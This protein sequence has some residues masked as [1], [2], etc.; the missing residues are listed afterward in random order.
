MTSVSSTPGR[1]SRL[2]L[3]ASRR[4]QALALT[5][6]LVALCA[7]IAVAAA[8]L[9]EA[10]LSMDETRLSPSAA[11]PFG[12]DHLGRD[13]ALRTVQALA[14]SLLVGVAASA[15]A[16]TVG[17]LAGL[18][19]AMVGGWV[20]AFITWLV[21]ALFSVPHL[22][23]MILVAFALGGGMTAIVWTVALTHWG[24]IT[25]LMR[26]EA[27][28][29][30]S[31]MFVRAAARLGRS[32]WWVA[33]RHLAPHLLPQF[34]TGLVLLFPHAILHESAL[35]FI[36][37]GFSP[38]TPSIGVML[39][40]AMTYVPSGYWWMVVFPGAGLLAVVLAFDALGNALRDLMSPGRS[41]L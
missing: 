33:R 20:D 3:P 19:A 13:V 38:H 4:G 36:G 8:L 39:A 5:V 31:A 1:S 10:R 23:L 12:T 28:Q 32:R 18:T 29:L 24:G 15:V 22:V 9:P 14:R 21:D 30:R 27:A 35:S 16:A 40:E 17:L 2:P 26:A 7:A 11:H 41:Q 25:R 6:L 37:L 34:V